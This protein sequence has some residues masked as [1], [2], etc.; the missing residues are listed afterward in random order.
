MSHSVERIDHGN[1]VTFRISHTTNDFRGC[2]ICGYFAHQ[3]VECT[4]TCHWLLVDGGE[5]A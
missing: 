3:T 2:G 4:C 5:Q 1:T